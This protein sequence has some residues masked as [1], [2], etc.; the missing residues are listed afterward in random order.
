MKFIIRILIFDKFIVFYTQKCAA[1]FA[2]L[3][4]QGE[5]LEFVFK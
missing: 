4:W 2:A 3:S 5:Q 1:A